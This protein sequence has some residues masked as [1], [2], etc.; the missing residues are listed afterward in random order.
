[1]KANIITLSLILF[2]PCSC[3][4]L[5]EHESECLDC[6][7]LQNTS[8]KDIVVASL[9]QWDIDPNDNKKYVDIRNEHEL[10]DTIFH[11]DVSNYDI[12]NWIN[13]KSIHSFYYWDCSEVGTIA[14]TM[15][16]FILDRNVYETHSWQSIVEN[17]EVLVRYDI[18]VRFYLDNFDFKHH[19]TYPPNERMS[20]IVVRYYK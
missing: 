2:L 4:F 12:F 16:I 5:Y 9:K 19:L 1:M 15:T 10:Y 8:E 7:Y 17:K 18:P 3:K 14:D 20:E 11:A 6:V 13:P